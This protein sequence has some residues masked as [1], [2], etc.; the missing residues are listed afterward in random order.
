MSKTIELGVQGMTCASCVGRVERGLGKV[1]GVQ[2][3]S[4]NL[5]TERATVT[6][7]P[8][9]TGPQALIARVKDVGYEPVVGEIELG[10]QGMTCASCVSRVERALKKVD[11]VLDASVNLATER[12]TVR[13]LPSSVSA[14]QLKAAVKGA[15]YEVLEAQAGRDRTDL[16]REAREQEIH[17]LRRAVTFSAVFALPLALLAM[18]PM[19]VPAVND[20]L[21]STFGHGV[22]TTLNWVMLALAVPVQFGPGMRFYRL[23]WK[24]LRNRSPDMNSLVMIGTSA[25]FFYSLVVTL[26]PQVFP[27]GTAHVYYEAAAVVITLIL[28]GKYFEAIAKGRSSEAMKKLLSLQAKTARVVRGGQE[29]ELPT[30]EVL[31]GDLISVRPGEKVPVDGEVTLGNS[32][33]DESMITGEPIP[34][35]KQAGAAVVG[36]TINQN[37]AFQFRATK[38]GADTA[39]AQIIKLVES[40]QGSK[41]P[42]QGLADRVVSV[43]VPI[44]IGIAALTFLIWMVVGGSTA[45]SFALVTTVAVLIIACPC[46]MGLATPTSIMVGTG[47]AAELGVLFRN[48]AALEGLQGANVVAVDK[49]GT[50]TK[51]KPDLTDLVTAPGFDRTEVLKLVAAAE[52]QSEHPIARAIVDAAKREGMAILPLEGFEAVPGYGL[53]ARVEG[54][55]VQV[56]ADRYMQRLGLS[57]DNFAAQAERLGDEGKSPLYA[58][59]D[60]QLAAVIAVADPIKEGSPE[61]VKALH[62]QGLRVAMITGDNARTANAIA[63]QL[64]IDEVLAEVLPGGKSD[65]VKELQGKGQ[66]VAFVGDGINDAPALAQADVGLAIGTGTDV[67][68]ETADVIL[69]SGDL[70][71]V[72]N[73]YALSRATLR[74]IKLNLFWAFAYNIVLI[75][76]AAGVLY[77]AFGWLLSPVLAAAAMGFSSVFV[78]S[79]ALRLRSFRPPVR[80]DPVPTRAGTATPARA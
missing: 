31:I 25:A 28:L 14:G 47:K 42:I 67:A 6:Y 13:Y 79:N 49:T 78:L 32:F 29:L 58:A 41:P 66:K 50:L 33:V 64:G 26:A 51:G 37:G 18:V 55:L 60:G 70:R 22:M 56:G 43:F 57:V 59:I 27:E 9:Q 39:L 46:A 19:L 76:V 34:V 35:A 77:P 10:V 5:A 7:D 36:G 23:G 30:D 72:P 53:E 74:N 54:R 71:G 65:A 11:G 2:R 61:A 16:E 17:G 4:V 21:M 8:E 15:G 45:L 73:A 62:R 44:V 24:A 12:A 80:P 20:W 48:G 68:V 69:M 40:A 75:P 3:A 63:R 38:I 1:E 52:E